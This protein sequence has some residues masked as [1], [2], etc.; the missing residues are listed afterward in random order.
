MESQKHGI[1]S[2]YIKYFNYYYFWT[3]LKHCLD[4][5]FDIW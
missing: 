3:F 2:S 5:L 1:E 4:F